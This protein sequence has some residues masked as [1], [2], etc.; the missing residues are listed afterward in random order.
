MTTLSNITG[1]M[2]R[3]AENFAKVKEHFACYTAFLDA[4]AKGVKGFTVFDRSDTACGFEHLGVKYY[5]RLTAERMPLGTIIGRISGNRV[6]IPNK[7]GSSNEVALG[8]GT[9]NSQGSTSFPLDLADT[10]DL[11]AMIALFPGV[12]WKEAKA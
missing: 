3:D 11:S 4:L 8:N 9:M 2:S 6:S 10:Y 12:F 7:D 1:W 5:L